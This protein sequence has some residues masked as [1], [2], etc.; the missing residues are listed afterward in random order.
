MGPRLLH[1]PRAYSS[2]REQSRSWATFPVST[3]RGDR[4]FRAG[5][6]QRLHSSQPPNFW[7]LTYARIRP[8][9]PGNA[10]PPRR[11]TQRRPSDVDARTDSRGPP[12]LAGTLWW[13][14]S[15]PSP[16]W[17]LP[18]FGA[19]PSSPR[20]RGTTCSGRMDFPD[21]VWVPLGYT[22]YGIIIPNILPAKI[23]GNAQASFYFWPLISAGVLAAVT[24]LAGS[25]MVGPRGRGDRRGRALHQ[26]V[27]LHDPHPSVPR[28]H[29]DDPRL[30]W[31]LLCPDGQGPRLPGPG[32]RGV[33]SRRWFLPRLVLRG[34]RDGPVRLA[35][36]DRPPVAARHGAAHARHRRPSC[37]RLGG[38]RRRHRRRGL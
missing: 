27:G 14:A 12:Q 6:C 13:P 30:Q 37:A 5:T 7:R 10:R 24:Y 29:G 16:S 2:P 31:R 32:G 23:F 36:G 28:P 19:H 1:L 11:L 20:T 21:R 22:R 8:P 34:Q 33:G 26:L 18:S 15:W 3:S 35:P 9:W 17:W 38:A 25:P 4:A